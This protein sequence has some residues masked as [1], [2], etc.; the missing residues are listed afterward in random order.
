M[1]LD[2]RTSF[3]PEPQELAA[4]QT[5]YEAGEVGSVW[6]LETGALRLDRMDAAGGR[7]VQIVL[8]GDLLGLELL[9]AYPYAHN[10]RAIVPS[11]VRRRTLSG[12]AERR[13]VMME[14]LMQQQRRGEDLVMLRSGAAQDRLK[15]L[16]LMLAPEETPWLAEGAA[17]ALPTI[18]DM[19]AIIDTSPE[20]VSR[21]FANLKRTQIL[22][23]RERQSARFS[24]A[25][26]RESEWPTGMTRSDGGARLREPG[27]APV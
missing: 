18:K 1:T 7:F 27:H 15:H 10:A 17:C 21:I 19:A 13:L 24:L 5:L 23:S 11:Q 6:Q 12:E 20:T 9:V 3:H 2:T 14:G 25:R 4:G 16:L 22:D 26:L 8:P